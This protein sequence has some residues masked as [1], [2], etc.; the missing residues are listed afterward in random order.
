M[1]SSS[2]SGDGKTYFCINMASAYAMASKRTLLVD[3]DIRKP[4]IYKQLDCNNDLGVSN[5]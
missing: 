1:V 3:M 4:S 2:E 5:I